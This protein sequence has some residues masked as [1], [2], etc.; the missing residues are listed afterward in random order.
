[1]DGKDDEDDR[2]NINRDNDK[3]TPSPDQTSIRSKIVH[4]LIPQTFITFN[5]A[6]LQTYKKTPPGLVYRDLRKMKNP[7]TGTTKLHLLQP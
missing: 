5:V 4:L 3:H 7:F 1:M 6:L 2:D